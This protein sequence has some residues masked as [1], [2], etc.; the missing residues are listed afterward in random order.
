MSG[1]FG[2][3]HLAAGPDGLRDRRSTQFAGL[4]L[5]RVPGRIRLRSRSQAI[6]NASALLRAILRVLC[7]TRS[8]QPQRA[9]GEARRFRQP[10]VARFGSARRARRRRNMLHLAGKPSPSLQ[11]EVYAGSI[12]GSG[13]CYCIIA[14]RDPLKQIKTSFPRSRTRGG[15]CVGR[16]RVNLPV[17]GPC[18]TSRTPRCDPRRQRR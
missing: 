1:L 2:A 11:R 3:A 4:A 7:V 9:A 15:H 12:M 17:A 5:A 13:M 6:A 8:I 18:D 10:Y 14:V 16:P